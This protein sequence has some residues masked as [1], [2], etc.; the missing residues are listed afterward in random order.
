MSIHVEVIDDS[1][2]RFVSP[3]N[4]IDEMVQAAAGDP[5]CENKCMLFY[6][7]DLRTGLR[8]GL[9]LYRVESEARCMSIDFV[10]D[11]SKPHV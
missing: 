6:L 8:Q 11:G 10:K 9:R 3:R 4:F 1:K 2:G 5:G 7:V